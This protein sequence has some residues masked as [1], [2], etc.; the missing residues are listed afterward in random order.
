MSNLIKRSDYPDTKI[1]PWEHQVECWNL[2]KD[3][4]AFYYAV[5][6]GGGKTKIFIDSCT[7]HDA[8]LMLV[9]CPKKVISHW[10]RQFKE[11]CAMDVD[12]VAP[13]KKS[14]GVKKKHDII[15]DEIERALTFNYKI[16]VVLNFEAFWRPPLGP[17]Y[18]D[19]KRNNM[20]DVGLLAK[21]D[22]DE[23]GIDEAHRIMAPGGRASW[24][25]Y[26][27]GRKA[28]YRRALSG[29]PMP[30]GPHNVYGQFRYLDRTMFGTS[31][32]KFQR[33]FCEMGGFENRQII[34]YKNLDIL[35]R[36]FYSMAYRVKTRDVVDMPEAL[37]ERLEYNLEPATMRLYRKF[38]KDLVAK[39]GTGE[40][41][42]SNALVKLLRLCQITGGFA[43]LDAV[44]GGGG[45]QKKVK[46]D[47]TAV[48]VLI[49]KIE[50]L[51]PTEKV[52]IYYRFTAEVKEIKKRLLKIGRTPGEISGN[53]NDEQKWIDGK[54]D[55][56]CV[57]IKAGG[58]GLDSL[59]TARYGFFYSKG[60]LSPGGLDQAVKRIERPGQA[61]NMVFYHLIAKGTIDVKTERGLKKGGN[62]IE[63]VLEQMDPNADPFDVA[64]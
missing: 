30:S 18:A 22:W 33:E 49:E 62:I 29:T 17:V 53:E 12:V 60:M 7:G 57:Q 38:E 54:V 43:T 58:E 26:R 31:Y 42:A 25:A 19:T 34:R 4:P 36:K 32:L 3:M 41:T 51:D 2:S 27:L 40:V 20:I 21:Y 13:D 56:I 6:M 14:W 55:A 37:H 23:M 24:G 1:E 15:K 61:R 11:H 52:V 48:D 9:I 8:N 45:R 59:K 46:V 5:D 47:T 28:K 39:I 64:A 44:P 10:P 63:N 50:D 35:N 16:A